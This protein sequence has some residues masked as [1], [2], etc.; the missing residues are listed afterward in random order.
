M[1]NFQVLLKVKGLFMKN[2]T[3]SPYFNA[4]KGWEE[5]CMVVEVTHWLGK[6][7]LYV[8]ILLSIKGN[9]HIYANAQ[10]LQPL[11]DSIVLIYIMI[12]EI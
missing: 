9:Q 8:S 11:V 1:S 4:R 3:Q 5:K 12:F 6:Y 7:L 2:S 10:S